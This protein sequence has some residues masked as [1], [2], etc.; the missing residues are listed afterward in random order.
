MST[1]DP[2]DTEDG[3]HPYETEESFHPMGEQWEDRMRDEL[4][5]TDY[6]ADLGMEMARDAQRLVAGELTEEEFYA[7]YHDDVKEEFE[8]DERPIFDDLEGVDLDEFDDESL[9]ESLAD[10]D[11]SADDVSRRDMM[12]KMGAAGLFLGYSAFATYDD[13][14]NEVPQLVDGVRP[15]DE[16]ERK[17]RWG[18]TI[19][20]ERCD[21]CLACVA[22]CMNENGTS[23]GAN[24]MYV[25]TYEDEQSE[26]ENPNQLVRPCQHCSNAP[27][28]KVCPVR[29]RHTRSK[30]GLVLTNYETCIGCRYC[31]VAC[32]YGVNYF[33]WGDPDVEMSELNHV[34]MTPD[35]V[36][37]LDP[38]EEAEEFGG[39]TYAEEGSER[40]TELQDANDHVYDG[41]GWWTDSRPPIGTMGKCTMC[42]S[43]QDNTT[44][45]TPDSEKGSVACQDACDQQGMSAIHFGDLD[46]EVGDDYD[47]AVRYL[48][49]RQ[50][51][52]DTEDR[53]NK[54][55][56][57]IFFYD[58]DVSSDTA[59]A[60]GLPDL[61]GVENGYYSMHLV[62]RDG[63]GADWGLYDTEEVLVTDPALP[64][65][66]AFGG[67]SLD[68]FG[69]VPSSE[70]QVLNTDG[71][72][73]VPASLEH[74]IDVADGESFESF[75][76]TVSLQFGSEGEELASQ[77]IT[78]NEAEGSAELSFSVNGSMVESEEGAYLLYLV[79][80][81]DGGD[82]GAAAQ[83][84]VYLS[85]GEPN[86][87]LPAAPYD[88][89]TGQEGELSGA[90]EILYRG[91]EPE[92]EATIEYPLQFG[93]DGNRE[94]GLVLENGD[95]ENVVADTD[96]RFQSEY[97]SNTAWDSGLS[98]FK[99]LEDLGTSPNITYIGNEP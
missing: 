80:Q 9:L 56:A 77:Q 76:A 22:G 91:G 5:D 51:E 63:A 99:L 54:F 34:D 39:A 26:S 93:D 4:E 89:V 42:P 19:D 88:S 11:L 58:T 27:C 49:E 70:L 43:R 90:P 28:A 62:Q 2:N 66:D 59:A 17:H 32:P 14:G 31:Q 52:A 83:T 16:D 35:E 13:G 18:M 38:G 3:R 36:R 97:T 37:S 84:P 98:T 60:A 82:A 8:A 79:V 92:I 41:R 61:S 29:A 30:D 21:G 55:D 72:T 69:A 10:V 87:N 64:T 65:N 50:S 15:A 96:Y 48:E 73:E 81:P 85:A 33:Q 75:D 20:L 23:T 94:I 71:T 7:E 74:S 45:D 25:F 47:R 6:D 46:A 24:W 1:E 44:G 53:T 67:S 95:S 40:L 86:V 68:S 78:I 57:N 12:N